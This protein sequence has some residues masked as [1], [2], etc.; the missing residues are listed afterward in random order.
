M[1]KKY[2]FNLRLLVRYYLGVNHEQRPHF[3]SFFDTPSLTSAFFHTYENEKIYEILTH[4]PLLIADVLYGR[5]S[6]ATYLQ[7]LV[8]YSRQLAVRSL[9]TKVSYLK[10]M[11]WI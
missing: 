3:F 2:H 7:E 8:N 9:R 5:S 10:I 4:I 6:K 1:L 11:G